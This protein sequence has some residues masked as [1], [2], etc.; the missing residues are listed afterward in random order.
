[1][2]DD[3]GINVFVPLNS[4]KSARLQYPVRF[5]SHF[6][7]DI[8]IYNI[9]FIAGGCKVSFNIFL[10]SAPRRL[11]KFTNFGVRFDLRLAFYS[12]MAIISNIIS[13]I[14]KCV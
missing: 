9:V 6:I 11:D 12:N 4:F 7:S 5:I 1:M 8:N 13:I 14:T 2:S 3:R 10:V